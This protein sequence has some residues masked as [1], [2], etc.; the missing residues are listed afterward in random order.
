MFKKT[1]IG[2][3]VNELNTKEKHKL[4]LL[5]ATVFLGA[6][7]ITQSIIQGMIYL[8]GTPISYSELAMSAVY[9]S[10]LFITYAWYRFLKDI[11]R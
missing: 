8:A 9:L 1:S 2:E 4:R 5:Y 3:V 6:T 7:L 10:F 11:G